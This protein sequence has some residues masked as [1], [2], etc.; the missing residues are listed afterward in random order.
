MTRD[1]ND[2]PPGERDSGPTLADDVLLAP[3]RETD[4]PVLTTGEVS[5]TV[6]FGRR[7]T[8]EGLERLAGEGVV[9]R[10]S[11]GDGAVWWLPGHTDTNERRGPMPGATRE[12]DGGL[13][14]RLENAIST[15]SVPD[16]RERGAVYAA[17]YFLSE[18]GPANPETL[19]A[20]VY[21]NYP[22]GHD[23]A[24]SWWTEAIRPALAALDEVERDGDE[25]RIAPVDE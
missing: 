10:K 13:S 19:R 21:A 25:W 22:A 1:S 23:D 12:Y 17:C 11:V 18:Y 7:S 14:T 9:E 8:A 5:D 6:P 16:E 4:D 3:L 2:A 15:L 24:E 20:E